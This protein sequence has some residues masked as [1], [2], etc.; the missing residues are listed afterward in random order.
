MKKILLIGFL[1][2]FAGLFA[3]CNITGADQI[4]VGERQQYS[5]ENAIA[6]CV[7]CY[8]WSY[9][10]QKIILEGNTHIN[11]LTIKGAVQGNAILSLEIKTVTG[12][13]KCKKSIQVIAPTSKVLD[14]NAQKCNIEIDAF[15]EVRISDTNVVLEAIAPNNNFNY[16]WTV[17]YRNGS[18]KVSN[19]KVGTFAFSNEKGIDLV[20]LNV[21]GKQC[22][23]KISKTYNHNFWYFF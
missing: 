1:F 11:P 23:K 16:Q 18:K 2:I 19:E 5:A 7:D 14:V 22:I 12:T 8:D 20:E 13:S 17:H 10:D 21:T 6:D 9:M 4:Q 3:Q 15:K